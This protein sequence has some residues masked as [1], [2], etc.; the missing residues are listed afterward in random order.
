MADECGFVYQVCSADY[1]FQQPNGQYV[2]KPQDLP[3]AHSYSQQKARTAILQKTPLVIIDNTHICVSFPRIYLYFN[4]TH[5][6]LRTGK[7]N[8][9]YNMRTTANTTLSY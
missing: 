7:C 1:Y 9:T 5:L 8:R 2:F 6:S 4:H 3:D